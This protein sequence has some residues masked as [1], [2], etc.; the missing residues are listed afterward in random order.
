M[1]WP[2]C[3]RGWT[4]LRTGPVAKCKHC[5]QLA[6]ERDLAVD[7]YNDLLETVRQAGLDLTDV[8]SNLEDALLEELE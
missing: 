4:A 6:A 3:A 1:S 2:A 7:A 5:E 8:L